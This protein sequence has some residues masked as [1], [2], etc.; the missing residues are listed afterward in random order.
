MGLLSKKE[1]DPVCG[2]KV[3]PQTAT[4]KT[5]HEGKTYHFCSQGCKSRFDE[6][7]SKFLAS[8]PTGM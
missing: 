2:M 8:G 4:T 7:P 1:T 5:E 6:N 3:D